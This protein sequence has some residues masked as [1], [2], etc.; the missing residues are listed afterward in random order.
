[1]VTLETTLTVA[2]VGAAVYSVPGLL[3]DV[4]LERPVARVRVRQRGM[5]VDV[6]PV[7]AFVINSALE[8]QLRAAVNDAEQ[9]ALL[10]PKAK[11]PAQSDAGG[12]L[13]ASLAV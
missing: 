2:Q 13:G 11:A 6:L 1:M 5:Y 7:G 12:A 4:G 9:V 8:Q 3:V 10:K